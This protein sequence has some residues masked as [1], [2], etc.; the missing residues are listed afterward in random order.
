MFGI[1]GPKS[2]PNEVIGRLNRETNT[3][4]ADPGIRAKIVD[5]GGEVFT[6]SPTEFAELIE[7]DAEKWRRVIRAANIKLE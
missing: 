5:L 6:G 1:A 2:T 7:R 4:L 3:V